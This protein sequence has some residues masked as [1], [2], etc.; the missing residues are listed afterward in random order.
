[1]EGWVCRADA[2]VTTFSA[3]KLFTTVQTIPPYKKQPSLAYH[4]RGKRQQKARLA[5]KNAYNCNKYRCCASQY[6]AA[7]GLILRGK[8]QAGESIYKG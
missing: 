2:A 4:I 8:M 3:C 7:V 6:L 5:T 1:M